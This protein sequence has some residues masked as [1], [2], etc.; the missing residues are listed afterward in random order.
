MLRLLST[1]AVLLVAGGL[2]APTFAKAQAM[3]TPKERLITITASGTVNAQ[4]DQASVSIGVVSTARTA[5]A[6][7][8][9]NS[10]S[11]RPVIDALKGAGI[12]DKDIATS[13][14]NLQPAYDYTNDGKPPKL[15][16]YQ[17]TN[18]V[19]A[20]V[21]DIAKLGGI[22]DLAVGEGSNQISGVSFVVSKAEELKDEARKD[23]VANAT[24][25]AKAYAQAAGVGL[26]EVQMITDAV[27]TPEY[28]PMM[29]QAARAKVAGPA[30]IEPGEQ[31]LEAQ[32]TMV[33]AIK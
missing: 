14:F 12:E 31:T 11:M 1:I 16:G 33:W 7:L 6:A 30:P 3:P 13:N 18:T 23:A 32:V 22:L 9:A 4:P 15:T 29:Q 17:V 26:G 8:A 19:S 10:A 25:M 20:R 27:Q 24:R 28:R 5:K 2:F 21:R